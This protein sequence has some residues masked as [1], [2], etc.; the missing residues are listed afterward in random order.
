MTESNSAVYRN[1][2]KEDLIISS[3]EIEVSPN[4]DLCFYKLTGIFK[5]K[6]KLVLCV[7]KGNWLSCKHIF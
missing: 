1:C 6:R 2:E 3:D 7:S 5:R 4:G